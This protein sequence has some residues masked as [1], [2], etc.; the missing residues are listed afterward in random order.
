MAAGPVLATLIRATEP[1]LVVTEELLFPGLLS[2]VDAGLVTCAV[3]EIL[4]LALP[5]TVP[6]TCKTMLLP[7]GRNGNDADK[8]VPLIATP[9]GQ[10]A[11]PVVLVQVMATLDKSAGELSVK[12]ALATSLGPAFLTTMVYVINPPALILAGPDLTTDKSALGFTVPAV[13][14]VLLLESGS[15][16]P[17]GGVAEA[18]FTS[19]PEAEA[20]TVPV[21]V[22]VTEL[23]AGK[24]GTEPL[25]VLPDTLTLAGHTA[26]PAA[27]PQLALSPVM[28]VGTVSVKVVPS[29]E[30]GPPLRTTIL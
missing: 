24:L 19:V 13:L 30:L 1:T 5:E 12:L 9:I 27:E 21:I 14:L 7:A 18:E 23:L 11:P 29:A 6:V 3:L 22:M 16:M 8:L 28:A 15:V 10:L 25:T 2:G 26:P 4:P 17:G 20:L